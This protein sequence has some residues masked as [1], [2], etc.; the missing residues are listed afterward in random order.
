MQSR[1]AEALR[2]T[3]LSDGGAEALQRFDAVAHP[4]AY[5]EKTHG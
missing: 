2:V 4:Q 3:H 1:V 5:Y